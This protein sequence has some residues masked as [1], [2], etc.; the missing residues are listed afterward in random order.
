MGIPVENVSWRKALK[1]RGGN[2]D[3]LL[4]LGRRDFC[5]SANSLVLLRSGN[6]HGQLL[7]RNSL[8]AFRL[9]LLRSGNEDGLLPSRRER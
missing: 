1:L 5:V 7:S 3:G 2:E 6:D 4:L 9:V 8:C